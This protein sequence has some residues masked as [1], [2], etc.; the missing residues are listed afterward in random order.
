MIDIFN[1]D[2]LK[3]NEGEFVVICLSDPKDAP[4]VDEIWPEKATLTMVGNSPI[5][6]ILFTNK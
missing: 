1:K 2:K 5:L 3:C 6:D 4:A